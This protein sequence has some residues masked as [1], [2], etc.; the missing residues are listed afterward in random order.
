MNGLSVV[1]LSLF[2]QLSVPFPTCDEWDTWWQDEFDKVCFEENLVFHNNPCDCN[3][4]LSCNAYSLNKCADSSLVFDPCNQLCDFPT[5]IECPYLHPA[6]NC[7]KPFP[8]CPWF[9]TTTTTNSTTATVTTTTA[10]A[11][12]TDDVT[13]TLATTTTTNT[14][15]TRTTTTTTANEDGEMG[16]CYLQ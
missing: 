7:P 9:S 14:T 2:L 4:F 11:T 1:F 16:E 8:H 10:T 3:T 13:T 6:C 15:T 12:T 5:E